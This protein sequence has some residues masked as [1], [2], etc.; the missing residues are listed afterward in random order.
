MNLCPRGIRL[1]ELGYLVFFMLFQ[2][3]TAFLRR[4]KIDAT[5]GSSARCIL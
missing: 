2:Y 4:R 3:V 1:A 5:G